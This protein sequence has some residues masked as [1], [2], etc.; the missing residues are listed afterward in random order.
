MNEKGPTY[1]VELIE[2]LPMDPGQT[3]GMTQAMPSRLDLHRLA[4]SND[5]SASRAANGYEVLLSHWHEQGKEIDRLRAVVDDLIEAIDQHGGIHWR[6]PMSYTAP[7]WEPL[8][9]AVAAAEFARK[10]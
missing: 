4:T 8:R 5:P 10:S 3:R 1:G 9:N 7:S 2:S 6:N